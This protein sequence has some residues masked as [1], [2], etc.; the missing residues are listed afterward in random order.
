MLLQNNDQLDLSATCNYIRRSGNTAKS[1]TA[2][3]S[4]FAC[5]QSYYHICQDCGFYTTQVADK[6]I[7]MV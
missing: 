5:S 1:A 3:A 6:N 4:P 2:A 7:H